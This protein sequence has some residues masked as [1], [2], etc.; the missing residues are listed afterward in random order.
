MK[1][2]RD[3]GGADAGE[4]REHRNFI[5]VQIDAD[6]AE[7]KDEGR[8][9]TRF[10]P[11]PNGYLHIGHAK[12][13]CLS[14]DLAA[15]YA[16]GKCNLRFDDTNPLAEE[17]EFVDAIQDDIRW[18]GYD[19][20]DRLFFASDYFEQLYELAQ[21][22][23]RGGHA[24][25]CDLSLEELREQRG[26]GRRPGV[27]SP[28]RDRPAEE[29][30]DLL[31]RMRAGEFPDGARTLRAKIDMASP[32]MN[33]RDPILYRILRG[34]HYRRGDEWCIYP[35]YDW[36]HGQS[37]AIEGITHSLCSL[38]FENH[39]PLYDWFLDH[40]SLPHRPRQIEFARLQLAYTVTSKRKLL[41]LVRDGHVDGWDDPRMPTLR[42]MR[43]RGYRPEAIRAF[44]RTIGVAKFNSTIDLVVLENA[45]RDD[46][47][48]VVQRRMAVLDPLEVVIEN[49]P[50]GEA[51]P[52]EAVNNPEDEAAGTRTLDLT[53]RV[54]IERTDFMEDAPRKFFRLKPGGEVRLRFGYVIRCDRVEKDSATGEVTRLVCSYDT[55]SAGGKTS[56]GRKVKGIV[57]WVSADRAVDGEVR[58][59]EPLF[60]VPDPG[61]EGDWLED[62][63]PDSRRVVTAK[64]EPSLA[65][66]EPG[67]RFQFERSGYFCAD[68][69]LHR[70]D[71]PVF[72][73]TVSLKDTWAKIA[74]RS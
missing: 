61:K 1:T 17:I 71:R 21:E 12:A 33:M 16:G 59:Y 11:E 3:T 62:L 57:H 41:S 6:L 13:V 67:E 15:E 7:G 36:T 34:H 22:L 18:L 47:N 68:A 60:R 35:T 43:R 52:C 19:W 14:F 53:R 28:Y 55:E 44:C 72:H 32:N 26:D 74:K 50:E 24:Y 2:T 8:V 40:L 56:D 25:V 48:P 42:G 64:L 20:E 38:E 37:D 5:Q 73:R 30:L 58:L 4:A 49:L 23:V 10:P 46:L 39:R 51:L 65:A 63:N 45:V 31:G 54:W 9:H 69:E 70:P 29:S 27:N 66:A